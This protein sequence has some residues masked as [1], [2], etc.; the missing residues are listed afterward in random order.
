M[1]RDE[2]V[3]A[4]VEEIVRLQFQLRGKVWCG[5]GLVEH[6]LLLLSAAVVVVVPGERENVVEL[7]EEGSEGRTWG[8]GTGRRWECSAGGISGP[9]GL[10]WPVVWGLDGACGRSRP[11]GTMRCGESACRTSF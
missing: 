6:L 10:L 5:S 11:P 7:A 1:E 2:K 9:S 4:A 8:R 3:A